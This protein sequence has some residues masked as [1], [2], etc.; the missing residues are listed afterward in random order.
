LN[1]I[2]HN[3]R[4]PLAS[5]TGALNSVLVDEALLDPS[6]RRE[7]LMTAQDEAKRLNRLVQN[8]LDMTRLEGGAVHVK[9]EPCDVQDLIGSAL[10]QLGD[11]VRERS[12]AVAVPP[13]LP[14]VPLDF[15]LSVQ[16]LVNLL[17]NALKYSPPDAPIEIGATLRHDQLEIKV[18]DR[19]RGI[20]EQ[21]LER[22]FEKFFR[23]ASGETPGGS[24]LGLSICKGLIEA[25]HGRIWAE[26]RSNGGTEIIF[27]LPLE[28]ER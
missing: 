26:H 15:V 27:S 25:Q 20:P 12:I 8:L 14:L 19:G 7:L 22:V 4:T 23:A 21:H 9:T 5:V 28:R 2:S 17:D 18:A 13:N 10:E 1:S 24:G 6:T 16:V 3:L 11:R